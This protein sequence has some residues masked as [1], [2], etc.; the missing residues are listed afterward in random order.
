MDWT[1]AFAKG[2]RKGRVNGLREAAEIAGLKSATLPHDND[3]TRGYANGRSAAAAEIRAD[4]DRI[5]RGEDA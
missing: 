2:Y 1:E 5:E 3:L 4:A